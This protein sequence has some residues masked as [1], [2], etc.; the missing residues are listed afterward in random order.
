[1]NGSSNPNPGELDPQDVGEGGLTDD[2][3]EGVSGGA[4]SKCSYCGYYVATVC[5]TSKAASNCRNKTHARK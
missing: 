5:T 1:M 4:T 3:L 2:A